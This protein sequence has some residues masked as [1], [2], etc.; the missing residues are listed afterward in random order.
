MNSLKSYKPF[1]LPLLWIMWLSGI[2]TVIVLMASFLFKGNEKIALFSLSMKK[3]VEE[4]WRGMYFWV[5]VVVPYLWN[6]IWPLSVKT[7]SVMYDLERFISINTVNLLS[8]NHRAVM[9]F[10]QCSAKLPWGLW[11]K[12]GFLGNTSVLLS[13]SMSP[14]QSVRIPDRQCCVASGMGH[15]VIGDY[16]ANPAVT[17]VTRHQSKT[18]VRKAPKFRDKQRGK[19][20]WESVRATESQASCADF[21][22]RFLLPEFHPCQRTCGGCQSTPPL[23]ETSVY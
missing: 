9:S 7:N 22:L 8:N 16:C 3:G 1:Y 2:S 5:T 14:G 11:R 18:N 19:P 4:I 13:P 15:P 20:V 23:T 10:R 17:L 6:G 21:Q 12:D